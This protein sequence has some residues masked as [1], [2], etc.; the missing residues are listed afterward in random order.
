VTREGITVGG[1]T[2]SPGGRNPRR[3]SGSFGSDGPPLM[4]ALKSRSTR[5]QRHEGRAPETGGWSVEGK[6]SEG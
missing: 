1:R 3:G 2:G 4:S 6:T 5:L